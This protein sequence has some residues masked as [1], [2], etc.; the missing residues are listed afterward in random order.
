MTCPARGTL[1]ASIDDESVHSDVD[2]H[3][4]GCGRCRHETA[5]L[6]ADAD[7]AAAAL[8]LLAPTG[9]PSGTVVETALSRLR[10]LLPPV[11]APPGSAPPGSQRTAGPVPMPAGPAPA[12]PRRIWWPAAAAA[13]ATLA[14]VTL[15]TSAG[16][17]A[18]SSFLEQ[19]RSEHFAA[20]RIDPARDSAALQE[21]AHLGTISGDLSTP[22]PARVASVAAAAARVGFAPAAPDPTRLP[23]G[24]RRTPDVLVTP[25]RELRFTFDV[26]KARAWVQQQS[27]RRPTLP[28]RFDGASLVVSVPSAVLLRYPN[29]DGTPAVIVGQARQVAARAEGGVSLDDIRAV[30]LELPGLSE[31]TRRQL[32][33]IGDW[34][35]TLPLPVPAGRVDWKHT[36]IAGA[37][38]LELGDGTGLGSAVVWQR[39]GRMYGVF[40]LAKPGVVRDVADSLR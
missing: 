28:D 24:A 13:V 39:D 12:R 11:S 40:A 36:T 3:L 9:A 33:A 10:P 4:A 22:E 1:R 35:T 25:A 32:Q 5:L 16:R 17:S 15:G 27:Q 34:R 26:A 30:L 38:A 31:N 23:A 18:A 2:R 29:A 20:V 37:D 6:R 19:F 7:A 21:L 8:A 14:F